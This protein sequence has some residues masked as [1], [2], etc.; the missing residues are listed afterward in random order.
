M[1]LFLGEND[2]FG[3]LIAFAIFV[4]S[5]ILNL[6]PG[7]GNYPFYKILNR[8]QFFPLFFLIMIAALTWFSTASVVAIIMLIGF[9]AFLFMGYPL[10][11]RER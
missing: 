9:L 3:L 7:A 6:I 11:G 4:T 5:Y 1:S 10:L 2:R 8:L